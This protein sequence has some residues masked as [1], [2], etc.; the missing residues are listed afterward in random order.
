L[1]GEYGVAPFRAAPD[2]IAIAMLKAIML[3]SPG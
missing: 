2:T 3:P 1:L